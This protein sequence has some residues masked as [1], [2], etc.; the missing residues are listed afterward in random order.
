[1][2]VESGFL[3]LPTLDRLK[4]LGAVGD[5]SARYFNIKGQHI[6][7]D[8]EDR[9]IGLS[10]DDLAKLDNVVAIACGTEKTEAIIG[11]LRTGLVHVLITD[12]QT[13]K[14]VLA[15]VSATRSESEAKRAGDVP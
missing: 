9:I 8:I 12:D 5:I 11:A 2:I 6:T 10:W 13:A 4:A 1:M 7:G 3:D 15:Y 14:A